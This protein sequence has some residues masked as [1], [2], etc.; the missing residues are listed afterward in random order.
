MPEHVAVLLVAGCFL[1]L[2]GAAGAAERPDPA[3]AAKGKLIYQRYCTSCHG[4]EGRG[5]GP[6]AAELRTAPTD[7]TRLAE[8]NTG[9]FPVELVARSIDGRRTV[10]A[11]GAPDMPVWGE[12]FPRTGGTDSPS[13]DS[14]VG[15]ITQYVWSIQTPR[16]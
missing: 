15:R 6:L 2:T 5:N 16:P 14:A 4:S 8:K 3:A 12:I 11:H 10:R 13:V 1:G 7:L 9:R